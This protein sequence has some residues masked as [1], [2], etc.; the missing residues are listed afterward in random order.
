VATCGDASVAASIVAG[1]WHIAVA[2]NVVKG[3]V[4]VVGSQS[5]MAPPPSSPP[6]PPPPPP[7]PRDRLVTISDR[8]DATKLDEWKSR[9]ENNALATFPHH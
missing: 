8:C 7:S 9:S 4:V 6:P 2:V 5:K 1:V 3:Q